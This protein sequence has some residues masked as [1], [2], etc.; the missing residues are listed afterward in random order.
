[1]RSRQVASAEARLVAKGFVK[2]MV[3]ELEEWVEGVRIDEARMEEALEPV[4]AVE[5][6]RVGVSEGLRDGV[7]WQMMDGLRDGVRWT[8]E[9]L[10]DCWP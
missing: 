6:L 4:R 9:P 7:P 5:P 3:E 8:M 2:V 1:M 10:R